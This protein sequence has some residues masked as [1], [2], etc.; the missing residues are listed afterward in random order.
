MSTGLDIRLP[1]PLFNAAPVPVKPAPKPLKKLPP[2]ALVILEMLD[3]I[4]P[5]VAAGPA[6]V[7]KARGLALPFATSYTVNALLA[8]AAIGC[9][10]PG[11]N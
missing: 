5:P 9:H 4:L 1:I 11:I 2:P 10:G 8:K 7:S 3:P 6:T